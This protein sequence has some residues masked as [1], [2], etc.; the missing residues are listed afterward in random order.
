[1]VPGMHAQ[2]QWL[3]HVEGPSVR[4]QSA[5]V[6]KEKAGE[7]FVPPPPV[8]QWHGSAHPPS[9]CMSAACSPLP[10]AHVSGSTP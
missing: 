3:S 7:E 5:P 1:M 10:T 2:E 9:H 6:P 8:S 4:V